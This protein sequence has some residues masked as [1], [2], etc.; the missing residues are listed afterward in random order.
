MKFFLTGFSGLIG[1]SFRRILNAEHQQ[2]I[3]LGR[4]KPSLNK[5][6]SYLYYDLESP[7]V[8]P[9][10]SKDEVIILHCAYNFSSR[11]PFSNSDS[12]SNLLKAFELTQYKKFVFFSTPIDHQDTSNLSSYQSDKVRSESL[13][14]LDR[15]LILCPSFIFSNDSKSSRLFHTIKNFHIPI[16]IPKNSNLISPIKVDA[17]VH[18]IYFKLILENVSGK[19]LIM[20]PGKQSFAAFLKTNFRISTFEMPYIVFTIA[21]SLFKVLSFQYLALRI[22]GLLRL[23]NLQ[24]IQS[25]DSVITIDESENI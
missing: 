21:V 4:E 19:F 2:V 9:V 10:N 24:K 11:Y 15:D 17:L 14:E 1:S 12:T 23:P 7:F 18:E 16:P 25:T 13:F 5:Y 6:E 8:S 3:L 20:G 22:E